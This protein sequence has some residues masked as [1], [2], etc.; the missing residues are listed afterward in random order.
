MVNTDVNKEVTVVDKTKIYSQLV[1]YREISK[2]EK[3]L[4]KGGNMK[5]GEISVSIIPSRGRY[6]SFGR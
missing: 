1:F 4:K 6:L 2:K 3:K 5:Q